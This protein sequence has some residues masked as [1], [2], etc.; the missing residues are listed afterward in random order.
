MG[1]AFE[2]ISN[3]GANPPIQNLISESVLSSPV[4][5]FRFFPFASELFLGGINPDYNE[6]DFTWVPLSFKVC[7]IFKCL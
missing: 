7:W 3:Y 2:Y 5:G 1:M 4:F 6:K